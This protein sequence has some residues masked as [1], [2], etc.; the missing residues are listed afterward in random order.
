M[1]RTRYPGSRLSAILLFLIATHGSVSAQSAAV[2]DS[3]AQLRVDIEAFKGRIAF[4]DSTQDATESA[5]QRIMLAPLCRRT[6]ALRLY[7]EAAFIADSADLD[8][9]EELRAR[10]GLVELYKAAGNWRKAFEEAER[11]MVLGA[12]FNSRE[13]MQQAHLERMNTSAMVGERDHAVSTLAAERARFD[14]R[15]GEAE[16]RSRLWML[17]AAGIGVLFLLTLVVVLYRAGRS[18]KRVRAE[19]SVLRAEVTALKDEA[20]GNRVRVAPPVV[21]HAEP[22]VAAPITPVA[23]PAPIAAVDP[24]VLAM[25]QKM[26]PERLATLRDARARGDHDKVVRVV[27]TLKPQL[28]AIDE[29]TF[30]DLCAA[31]S[32]DGAALDA[33]SWNAAVD[34]LEAAVARL[35]S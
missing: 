34:R 9:D 23:E 19:L 10:Q 25:F 26:A 7:E 31:I 12:Q 30:G 5:R 6:E 16:E 4:A 1:F 20:S 2:K 27:R 21:Q 32:A 17:I 29:A 35:L 22:V 28:V 13:A 3:L 8:G 11:S 33:P 24:V 15:M 14:A 18:S